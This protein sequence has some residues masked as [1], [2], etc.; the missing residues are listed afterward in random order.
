M[1]NKDN[2]VFPQIQRASLQC[3]TGHIMNPPCPRPPKPHAAL[4]APASPPHSSE[5]LLVPFSQLGRL[6]LTGS[7]TLP[8]RAQR[9]PSLGELAWA[10]LVQDGLPQPEPPSLRV[11]SLPSRGSRFRT[12]LR[13][14][15][16]RVTE[17]PT[18]EKSSRINIL[19][20][21]GSR[22]AYPT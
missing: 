2:Q 14:S 1:G 8:R 6:F 11:A 5:A 19:Q 17:H 21:E 22:T 10:G 15:G 9:P 3:P 7:S 13:A 20:H 16:R 12:P 18:S 4:L